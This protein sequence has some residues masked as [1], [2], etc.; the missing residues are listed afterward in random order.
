MES[1]LIAEDNEGMRTMLE[2]ALQSMGFSIE[3]AKDGLDACSKIQKEEFDLIITDLRMPKRD[4]MEVLKQAKECWPSSFVI[5]I[6]A[7]GSIENAVQAM[8]QGAFDY[9]TKPFSVEELEARVK[10]AFDQRRILMHRDYL[11]D[12]IRHH[13]GR[14]VGNSS[15]L[16]EMNVLIDK[17][18]AS[19]APVL[20]LGESGTGKELV[21]REIHERSRRRDAAFVPVNCAALPQSLIE[22]EL[23]G[24]E[25]GAFTGASSRKRGKV[26]LADRG[27]LF[28]DEVTEMPL[29]V[30]VKLLR[31]LQNGDFERVGGVDSI[32]VVARIIAATNQD[33]HELIH[34]GKF[35]EDVYYRINVFTLEL[36]ALREHKEDIPSLV[37]YFTGRLSYTLHKHVEVSADAM[38]ALMSYHWPGNVR[39]LENVLERALVLSDE[40]VLSI[41]ALPLEIRD[42]HF[43]AAEPSQGSSSFISQIDALERDLIY[44]AL[45]HSK[46]NQSQAARE[47]GIKRAALQYKIKK[48]RLDTARNG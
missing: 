15:I 3:I 9:L 4:G 42:G 34:Q 37:E 45:H 1:I 14:I 30:Q 41:D 26:E 19:P 35:R 8:R 36:P 6:T 46:G 47:L 23:F 11:A 40:S 24:H 28:L 29:E 31:F 17:I 7:H 21:A 38:E 5:V 32:H 48:H 39:E 2:R 27:T 44:Q 22:S 16:R 10:K 13:Y 12:N 43:S 20:I 33:I 25:K 18:S